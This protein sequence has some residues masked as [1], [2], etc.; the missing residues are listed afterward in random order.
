MSDQ[1]CTPNLAPIEPTKAY[2]SHS[3]YIKRPQV[4]VQDK[5]NVNKG[6]ADTSSESYDDVVLWLHKQIQWNWDKE[7]QE[8]ECK[9][10]ADVKCVRC[11]DFKNLNKDSYYK[12][13]PGISY[14]VPVPST[15]KSSSGDYTLDADHVP[16]RV[17]SGAEEAAQ[18]APTQWRKVQAGGGL[19]QYTAAFLSCVGYANFETQ[20]KYTNAEG[21][22]EEA[23]KFMTAYPTT[24][25]TDQ[26]N[27][28]GNTL[29][30]GRAC[31]LDKDVDDYDKFL[32][33]FVQAEIAQA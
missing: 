28:Q 17:K 14:V 21:S 27:G 6:G 16:Y 5:A 10:S 32:D 18:T 31:A 25:P 9:I 15:P 4:L 30:N 29:G 33:E 3:F 22:E 24:D 11:P 20:L 2:A 23:W 1:R 19:G 13:D 7:K 26:A 8:R 12:V